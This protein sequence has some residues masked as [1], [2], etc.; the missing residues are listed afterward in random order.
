M[1]KSRDKSPPGRDKPVLP[2]RR[3]AKQGAHK[4]KLLQ[5]HYNN[6]YHV[7]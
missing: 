7:R 2:V 3:D 4:R 5:K 1:V 6:K